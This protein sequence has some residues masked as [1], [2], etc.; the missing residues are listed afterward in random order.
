MIR[1][2]FRW[3]ARLCLGIFLI[4]MAEGL[5]FAWV[6][7]TDRLPQKSEAIVAFMGSEKRIAAAY[8]LANQ[9]LASF[10]VLSPAK[11]RA[12]QTL[13][14]KY[15]LKPTITHVTEDQATTTFENALYTSQIVKTHRWKTVTLVTSDYHMPRSLALLDSFLAGEHVDIHPYP[16]YPDTQVSKTV[17]LKLIYNEMVEFWGSMIEFVIWQATGKLSEKPMEKS[18][19][20]I[21]LRSLFLMDVKPTW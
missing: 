3:F 14:K 13:D 18:R 19:L 6:L 11:D 12:Q 15:N 21:L 1:T 20:S 8:H 5:Y 16:V 9:D 17:M 4:F 2:S 7:K 10:M